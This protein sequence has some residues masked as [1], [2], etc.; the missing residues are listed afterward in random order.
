MLL[1]GTIAICLPG[2]RKWRHR[3][4]QSLAQVTQLSGGAGIEPGLPGSRDHAFPHSIMVPL[5]GRWCVIILL[6]P[7]GFGFLA[8]DLTARVG[9][10]PRSCVLSQPSLEDDAQEGPILF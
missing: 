6:K 2:L 3:E 4:V 7:R 5:N 8:P 10:E 9:F 1:G